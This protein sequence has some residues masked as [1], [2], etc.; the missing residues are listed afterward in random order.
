MVPPPASP[1]SPPTASLCRPSS[2]PRWRRPVPARS[3]AALELSTPKT[4][5]CASHPPEAAA[6]ANNDNAWSFKP[7]GAQSHVLTGCCSATSASAIRY[8]SPP[9]PVRI[10]PPAAC[11]VMYLRQ[12]PPPPIVRRRLGHL[13]QRHVGGACES[14]PHVHRLRE[15]QPRRWQVGE[16]HRHLQRLRA[17]R[18][19]NLL[20]QRLCVC[21]CEGRGAGGAQPVSSGLFRGQVFRG[22][23]RVVLCGPS[24]DVHVG[25]KIHL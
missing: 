7:C 11:A 2:C 9:S 3:S 14:L 24:A 6:P 25:S 5:A 22:S 1:P 8:R 4:P 17:H 19:A 18:V 10:K 12:P 21:G 13:R 16:D 15:V 20:R 23:S